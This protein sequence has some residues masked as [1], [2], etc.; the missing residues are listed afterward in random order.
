MASNVKT[1]QWAK[2][3]DR[4]HPVGASE[5]YLITEAT[6]GGAV[7]VMAE[8]ITETDAHEIV[9]ALRLAEDA[10]RVAAGG[11]TRPEFITQREQVIVEDETDRYPPRL[12]ERPR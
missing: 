9:T 8:A 4:S 2:F 5:R 12:P 3:R 1:Y 11:Y 10:R 7:R 6:A